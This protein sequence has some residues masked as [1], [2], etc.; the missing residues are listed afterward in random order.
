M[1]L[2]ADEVM[3][4]FARQLVAIPAGARPAYGVTF[5]KS[6]GFNWGPI[7]GA[8]HGAI[9]AFAESWRGE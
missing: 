8:E 1:Q 2:L 5:D 6:L 9:A 3:S 7:A 4:E